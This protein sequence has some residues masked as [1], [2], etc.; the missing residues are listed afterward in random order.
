MKKKD[1]KFIDVL[2]NWISINKFEEGK[3][4]IKIDSSEY[5]ILLPFNFNIL[6][7]FSFHGGKYK[8]LGH[9]VTAE[10]CYF[11]RYYDS[12]F[13]DY[14]RLKCFF[15]DKNIKM[16]DIPQRRYVDDSQKKETLWEFT[17]WLDENDEHIH[18]FHN[19]YN[20][21]DRCEVDVKIYKKASEIINNL[22]RTI[23]QEVK[24]YDLEKIK[25]HYKKLE[26]HG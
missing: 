1:N 24:K 25:K 19:Y 3:D 10:Y 26:K 4:F 7:H 9:C 15:F 2:N 11:K 8:I 21:F 17:C 22:R 14:N 5:L 23:F 12:Q 6:H 13:L 16:G 18:L 20:N